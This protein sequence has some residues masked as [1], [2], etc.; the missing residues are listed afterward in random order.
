MPN[1]ITENNITASEIL[2]WWETARQLVNR[3]QSINN[4]TQKRSNIK[5]MVTFDKCFDCLE[6]LGEEQFIYENHVYCKECYNNKIQ[7]CGRC[8]QKEKNKNNFINAVIEEGEKQTKIVLCP[9]C[10]RLLQLQKCSFNNCPIFF[11]KDQKLLCELCNKYY[12]KVHINGHN[13]SI[14]EPTFLYHRYSSQK[15]TGSIE[16]AKFIKNKRHVGIELECVNGNPNKLKDNELDRRIG[17]GHDGSVRGMWPLEIQTPPA[18]AS[19]LEDIIFHVTKTLRLA[20]YKVNKSCGVHIHI[21][22][23]DFRDDPVKIFN[24]I[25]LYYA[26][27]PL[28][29]AMLPES[30]KNNKY[31]LPLSNWIDAPKMMTLARKRMTLDELEK[32]WFKA[33]SNS[34]VSRYKGN[35]YDSSRY[36]GCNLHS[37]FAY[38]HIEIRYHHG[39]LNATKLINWI[40]LHLLLIDWAVNKYNKNVIDAL[41]ATDKPLI[42]LRLLVR[43]LGMDNVLRRYIIRR[44]KKF[45]NSN[46]EDIE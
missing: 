30:R 10:I 45:S 14:G 37:L 36:H 22:S 17:V 11:K 7:E 26:V 21:D 25:S 34:E 1:N 31:A 4:K 15:Q 3:T 19:K 5:K 42:K 28:I 20:G 27:E 43:H 44:L 41:L 24:I 38:G 46:I 6:K 16:K 29:Y 18:S 2:S 40:N 23:E 39:T 9:D 13:C 32:E 35:K 12:C 8:H 33:R